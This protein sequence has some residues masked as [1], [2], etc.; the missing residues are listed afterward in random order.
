[1]IAGDITNKADLERLESYNF[2]YIFHQAAISDTTVMDQEAVLR[3]N[4]NAY[5]DLLDLCVRQGA[6]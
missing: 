2:D 6:K 5:K 1:M 3:A 4:V